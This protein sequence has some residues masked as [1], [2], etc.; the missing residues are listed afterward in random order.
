MAAPSMLAD[1]TLF[2]LSLKGGF[3][4]PLLFNSPHSGRRYHE[5]F[6]R[7]A[8][9]DPSRL[10]RSEDMAVDGLFA[11][12]VDKGHAL[13]KA[14][15]PRAYVDVNREPYELDPR[16]FDGDMPPFANTKS[17][18]VAAGLGTIA[19]V[20]ADGEEIYAKKWP[21]SEAL[22]RIETIYHPYHEALSS[23][24][25]SIK[26]SFG[27][28]VL[29]DCHSMPTLS[30]YQQER[31]ADMVIGDRFGK[32]CDPL[33]CDV[34]E[35]HLTGCGYKVRR[36]KPFAGGFITEHY[37]RPVEGLHAVQIEISRALYMDEHHYTLTSGFADL[38]QDLMGMVDQL[39]EAVRLLRP[40][41][42]LAAE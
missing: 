12:V 10:R 18:R 20:V 16:M 42:G 40:A 2:S 6:L 30:A 15:F 7:Q 37:G 38:Q 23:H 34:I 8:V 22:T 29:V 26:Q 4:T 11:P 21:V 31:R 13:F 17:L 24:L 5:A 27:Y 41:L 3:K 35:E 14:H 19:R 28:A 39:A 32:S 25:L 9:L 36:N 1:E 33:L